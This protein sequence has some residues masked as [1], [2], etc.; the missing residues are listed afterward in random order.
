MSRT[1]LPPEIAFT[2]SLQVLLGEDGIPYIKD[3][4]VKADDAQIVRNRECNRLSMMRA[5]KAA[6]KAKTTSSVG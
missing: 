1:P 6:K 3:A 5:R 4:E 2:L